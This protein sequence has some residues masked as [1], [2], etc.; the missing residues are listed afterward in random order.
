MIAEIARGHGLDVIGCAEAGR[1]GLTDEEQLTLAAQ[2]R[3]CIVTANRNDFMVLTNQFLQE[4]RAHAGVLVV[5]PSMPTDQFT[6]V[7][8]PIRDYARRHGD[9]PTAYLFDYLR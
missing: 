8:R 6:R 3:R 7:A 5:P 9:A 1:L 4:Q 2:E